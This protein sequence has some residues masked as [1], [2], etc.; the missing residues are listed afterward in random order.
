M[1][2]S[3]SAAIMPAGPARL[4]DHLA[5]HVTR[6]RVRKGGTHGEN[7]FVLKN[8][9]AHGPIDLFETDEK[10][11]DFGGK[12]GLRKLVHPTDDK[13]VVRKRA[14]QRLDHAFEIALRQSGV[15]YAGKKIFVR[16]RIEV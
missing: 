7:Q 5:Q 12:L 3:A 1:N 4:A 13:P 14:L 11:D 2:R 15:A 16:K 6:S 8:A 10:V 9:R